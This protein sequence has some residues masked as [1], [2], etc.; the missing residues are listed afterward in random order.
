MQSQRFLKARQMAKPEH[1]IFVSK[2]IA[3]ITQIYQ[4]LDEKGWTQKVFAQELGK[5]ESE[6]SKWMTGTH[7]FTLNSI[8]KIEATLGQEILVTP[9]SMSDR[10]KASVSLHA[11]KIYQEALSCFT[12]HSA[13]TTHASQNFPGS[14]ER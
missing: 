9:L 6:V 7:N 3:L 8:S 14:S 11:D 10:F 12:D 5:S 4:I 2:N 1:S 13:T